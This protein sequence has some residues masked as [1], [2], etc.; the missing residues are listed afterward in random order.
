MNLIIAISL[1][2]LSL[3]AF[4]FLLGTGFYWFAQ[5][6][7]VVKEDSEDDPGDYLKNERRRYPR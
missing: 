1:I 4:A 2:I 6:L 5:G 7:W 3:G